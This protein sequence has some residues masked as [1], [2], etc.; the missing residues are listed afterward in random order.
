ML[1]VAF[2]A[3]DT[4]AQVLRQSPFCNAPGPTVTDPVC[5]PPLAHEKRARPATQTCGRGFGMD[6]NLRARS[7][8]PALTGTRAL[9][10]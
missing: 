9:M 2:Q 6:T 7:S 10:I 5:F 8:R 3:S 1:F 4:C